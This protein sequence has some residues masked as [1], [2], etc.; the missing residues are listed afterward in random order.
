[1]AFFNHSF[2]CFFEIGAPRF[3]EKVARVSRAQQAIIISPGGRVRRQCSY[4]V[5]RAVLVED[6]HPLSVKVA[7]AEGV[8]VAVSFI[9]P[10]NTPSPQDS[11]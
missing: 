2:A 4:G 9:V 5:E 8:A 6:K 1:M 10:H 3:S 11:K 7:V